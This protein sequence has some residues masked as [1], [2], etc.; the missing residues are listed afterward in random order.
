MKNITIFTW[1]LILLCGLACFGFFQLAY[2]YHLLY[3]EQTSL[4]TYTL[5]QLLSYIEKPAVLSCLSGDFLL[6]FFHYNGAGAAIITSL[7]LLLG[8]T[9]Y[10]VFRVW[11]K[12]WIALVGGVIMIGWEGARLCSLTY[13]LSS[14]VSL[15]G[16]LFLF[17]LFKQLRGKRA[18]LCGGMIGVVLSYVLFGYGAFVFL[19]FA[20]LLVVAPMKQYLVA[21]L[22]LVAGI[23]LTACLS[24]TY[25]LTL[26]QAY[27]YPAT[28][29]WSKPDL[30]HERLLGMNIELHAANWE[31]VI[32]LAQPDMRMSLTSVC[33]NLAH[34]MQGDLSGRLMN[35][36]QPAGLGLF[37]PIDESS[38][39]FSTQLANE[40]W[41]HLGDMTMAEHAAMLSMIFSPQ[42][43]GAR[44]VQRLA[45]INLINGDEVAAKKYLKILS[46]TLAYKQWAKDRM[47]GEQTSEVKQWLNWKRTFLPEKDTLRVSSLDVA[48][49]LRL[50]L[51]ANAENR[52]ARDYLLCFHLLMKDLPA[53]TKDYQQFYHEKPSRLYAEALLIQL[54]KKQATGEEVKKTGMSPEV[55]IDFNEYNRLH[56][57]FGGHPDALSGQFG[58]TYW[59]YY[60]YAQFQ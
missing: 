34:A 11:V 30:M 54:M 23:A 27:Q 39:Y 28:E 15:I 59:F 22:M 21:G 50:L 46:R 6:Q 8:G 2:S 53:F 10:W 48:K 14:T 7:L 20:C 9:G 36:Y 16:G 47:P 24:N 43:K 13:P 56:N 17:L 51:E 40:V 58:K 55:V 38:T 42:H 29:W 4:F 5:L 25:L 18:L 19:F 35:Q 37:I 26:P 45:E 44:M 33:S 49:S 57:Q 32:Q 60:H 52:M 41:F 1:G 31:K 3:R 12:P